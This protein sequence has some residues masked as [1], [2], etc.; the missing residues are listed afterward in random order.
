MSCSSFKLTELGTYI[1]TDERVGVQQ[2]DSDGADFVEATQR[3]PRRG[4]WRRCSRSWPAV[5]FAGR[6][7][8]ASLTACFLKFQGSRSSGRQVGWPAT[9]TSTSARQ[10]CGSM[11]FLLPL[12]I[13][14]CLIAARCPP[15]S[16]PANSQDLRPRVLSS[17]TQKSRRVRV[18]ARQLECAVLISIQAGCGGRI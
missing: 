6:G 4:L 7:H 8:A 18:F 12:T 1:A 2:F 10:A 14:L 15:Q 5:G 9:R 11:S 3:I 17:P 13:R 16:D